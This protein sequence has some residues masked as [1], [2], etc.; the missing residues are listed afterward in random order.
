MRTFDKVFKGIQAG[1]FFVMFIL[2]TI[3]FIHSLVSKEDTFNW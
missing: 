1:L 2:A 3:L